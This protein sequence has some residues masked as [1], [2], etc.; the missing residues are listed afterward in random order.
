[1][2][3]TRK[4][5]DRVSLLFGVHMHQ[6]VDNFDEAV[7]EAV[8]KCYRPFFET[9]AKYP[10]FKFSVHCSGWLL[11]QIRE[12][13]TD[14]YENMQKLTSE[15]AIEWISAGFFEP[16]LSSIPSN[17]RV[18]QIKKLSRFIKKDFNTKPK[19]LWLTERVWESSIV[20]DIADSNIEFVLVD[21]YHFLSSGYGKK[22]MNGYFETEESAKKL[23][24]FP[25]SG[26]LRYAL[27]FF[28][29]D[30]AI[31]TIEKHS[32]NKNSAAIIFDD[33]EKFGLWPKTHEW[34]YEKGWLKEFIEAVLKN[35][36]IRTEHFE[37][38]LHKNN[39]NGL[40]YLGNT[41]YFEMG[42]WSL[43]EQQTLALEA[44]KEQVGSDYFDSTGIAF[45][46]GG[47]WKNFF[48]KYEE[49]N[50]LHKRMLY[51]SKK[52]HLIKKDYKEDLYKLQTNDVFWHGV[53]GGLYLPNLRDNAYRYL[54]NLEK[55]FANKKTIYE[56][57]DFDMDGF[58]ELKVLTGSLSLLFSAKNGAQM[59]EFGSLDSLFNWQNTITRR[60]EAYHEKILN[61][62][63]KETKKEDTEQISTIHNSDSIADEKLK[64]NLVFDW[65]LKYSF[66]DHFCKTSF[67]LE[68]F[69]GVKFKEI[70]DFANQPFNLDKKSRVFSRNGGIYTDKKYKT[71]LKKSYI[72]TKN[73]FCLE[74]SS[75][76]EFNQK[77]YYGVEFNLHFAHPHKILFND[78]LINDGLN[79]KE[80][81]SLR[82]VDDFTNQTIKIDSNQKLDMSA[83]ILKTVSQ[84]ESGFDMVAQQVS[85][86]L[87]MPFEKEFDLKLSIGVS[88][89]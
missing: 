26:A 15:G 1:M 71:T 69:R 19:G 18:K 7:D 36:N 47:I 39:S 68:D 74:I 46:K 86:V 82:I 79:L 58:D 63:D 40:A 33:A 27:P 73:S 67:S 51:M 30:N 44:L 31:R 2:I 41:S 48:I 16:V 75:Q 64:E 14:V 56:I 42:E 28:N 66:I 80:L 45:I 76:S 60:K 57:E 88:D 12:K 52:Q 70:G 62:K 3:N 89:V 65:H 61:P 53:F 9:M 13:Y 17:D 20:P 32:T 54:L 4:K 77:C 29:I 23:A 6:P 8:E 49:S 83:Y 35:K 21:D 81:K 10:Q 78:N 25:I 43:R 84:S 22:Q 55:S 85:F 11:E 38:Y 37:E 59:V 87:F 50:Y 24:L 72:F 34:V 5:M